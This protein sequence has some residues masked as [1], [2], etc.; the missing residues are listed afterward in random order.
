M[1]T[2]R[3]L[4]IVVVGLVLSTRAL[5]GQDRWRYRDGQLGGDLPS[6][7]AIAK[8]AA[9][10]VK[11]IHQRPAVTQEVAWCPPYFVPGSPAPQNG[12]DEHCDRHRTVGMIHADMIDAI[13]MAFG[14]SLKPAVKNTRTV[15][16][17]IEDKGVLPWGLRRAGAGVGLTVSGVDIS[18]QRNGFKLSK[19]VTF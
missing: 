10:D 7:S 2:T 14:P 1:N 11:T 3:T 9:S 19:S 6:V 13:S 4:A 8:V 16:S 18:I 15:T 17:Q 5:Q 12:P